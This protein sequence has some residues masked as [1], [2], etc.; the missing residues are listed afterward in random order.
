MSLSTVLP[1]ISKRKFNS[2]SILS[3]A[4]ICS[5]YPMKEIAEQIGTT[6]LMLKRKLDD[7]DLFTIA[8]LKRLPSFLPF[9]RSEIYAIVDNQYQFTKTTY[10]SK[11]KFLET[12]ADKK[13]FVHGYE[14]KVMDVRSNKYVPLEK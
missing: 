9:S 4:L 13:I 5:G 7:N 8:E 10:E 12:L 2:Y 3:K 6:P 11:L 1:K 14:K